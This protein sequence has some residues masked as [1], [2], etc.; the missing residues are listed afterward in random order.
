[1]KPVSLRDHIGDLLVGFADTYPLVVLD[2]DLAKSTT[3]VKFQKKYPERFVECGI[4][5]QSAMSIAQGIASENLIPVYVNFAMFV[6]GTAW[7]QLRQICY[8]NSNVKII[9]THPGL[10]NGPDGATHHAT[11]DFALTRSIPNLE[12]LVPGNIYELQSALDYAFKK[13]GPVYIRVARDNVMDDETCSTPME[14]GKPLVVSNK[15]NDLAIVYEG[16]ASLLAYQSQEALDKVGIQ[17]KLINLR[18]IKPLDEQAVKE[19]VK[20]CKAIITLENH[21]VIGGLGTIVSE[22]LFNQ[23]MTKPLMKIGIQDTFTE[24]GNT[25][26][27]KRKYGLSVENIVESAQ[28]LMD[29]IK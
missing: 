27:V 14:S 13:K 17:S 26:A 18:F 16:T 28:K 25:G 10:D 6:T 8:A 12:I 22:L 20:D 3:S 21:S 23:G 1:M 11:E 24:S 19:A 9:G 15:G 2:S 7:T 4:A 5:E 29:Y